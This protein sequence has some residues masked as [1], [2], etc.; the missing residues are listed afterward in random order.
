MN[1]LVCPHCGKAIVEHGGI[2]A[3][4]REL[5]GRGHDVAEKS[6]DPLLTDEIFCAVC[7][8]M[9]EPTQPF[10]YL[11]GSFRGNK[12]AKT[13]DRATLRLM[14]RKMRASIDLQGGGQ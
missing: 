13:P 4:Y 9:N 2:S 5:R 11:C 8:A 7:G 6:G 1:E 3:S 12:K 10:C 14:L